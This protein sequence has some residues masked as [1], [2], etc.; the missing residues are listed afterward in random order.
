MSNFTQFGL[1]LDLI[2]ALE[3][4]RITTPTPIQMET[5]PLA[6][7]G[8][9]ILASAH[10]G[11]G[12]TVA[13]LIPLILKL[14]QSKNCLALILAPTRELAIQVDHTLQQMLGASSRLR[15]A[16]LIGGTPLF[17]QYTDLK[18]KPQVVIGTPGRINDH[19]TRGSLKLNNAHYVIID[20]ADRM[21]DMGFGSQLDQIATFLPASRQTLMFSATVPLHIEKL[22]K[23]YLQNPQR[24]SIHSSFQPAPTIKQETVHLPQEEKKNRLLKE[25]DL[26][27]GAIIV[28][29]RTKR[30]ADSMSRE[31]R[32]LG[33]NTEAMHGDLSQSRREKVIRSFRTGKS[34]IMIATDVAARGLDI[35]H[36]L[37]VVNYDLP[38]CPEDYVHRIGRTGRAEAEGNALSLVS[39]R[40]QIKWK[41]IL[42]LLNPESARQNSIKQP[43]SPKRPP[44]RRHSN[45]SHHFRRQS[46]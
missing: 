33:Y 2:E 22:S 43:T 26:R 6:L 30:L 11:T 1:P 19:L 14:L 41:E 8:L 23:K 44:T 15:K 16:L 37:H 7:R 36:V 29:V 45:K 3:Q 13:Y 32:T 28:F 24:V 12:K 38:E 21:L 40:D 46:S 20:E 34:R 39:P 25:L 10:T 18:K 27:E 4:M 35:P 42:K 31:L 9:D 5:I 17:K